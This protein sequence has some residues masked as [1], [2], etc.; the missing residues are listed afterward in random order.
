MAGLG[1]HYE[2]DIACAGEVNPSTGYFLDIKAIDTAARAT[3]VV[4]ISAAAKAEGGEQQ[5][6]EAVLAA[7]AGG[8]NV[9]LGGAVRRVRWWLSPFF[10]VEVAMADLTTA[11][12][13]QRFEFAAAHR[14]HVDT[15]SPEENRRLFGKCNNP[16]GHGHNYIV[17]P[18]V[19]VPVASTPPGAAAH[20]FTLAD[21][22]R[23]VASTVMAR[24]D[25]MN[26]NADVPEFRS[27]GGVNPSVENIA[28]VCFEMLRGPIENPSGGQGHGAELQSV[29]VWETE[30]TSATYPG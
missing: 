16:S 4:A 14:L 18:A 2:L 1:A 22:E 12:I 11:V 28:R 17:E 5:R 21:L 13:R 23:A 7:A 9:A 27:P 19:R 10:S 8:L 15:L 3:A 26:L 24:F 20:G 30:K 25:H 29:T 6:P